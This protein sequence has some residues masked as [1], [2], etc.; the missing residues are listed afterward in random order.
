MF[1]RRVDEL[2]SA[3][4]QYYWSCRHS[5]CFC[6]YYYYCCFSHCLHFFFFLL[7]PPLVLGKYSVQ[8]NIGRI[9]SPFTSSNSY[10]G[11]INRWVIN[12]PPPRRACH[13]IFISFTFSQT[14][15]GIV[16][17]LCYLDE[18]L[19]K[20]P[21]A[22]IS[23][24]FIRRQRHIMKP[25]MQLWRAFYLFIPFV[26]KSVSLFVFEPRVLQAAFHCTLPPDNQSL[27]SPLTNPCVGGESW[28]QSSLRWFYLCHLQHVLLTDFY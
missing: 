6:F 17:L 20:V 21:L 1:Q 27:S 23:Q 26:W 2:C 18:V 11:R 7:P 16:W 5:A 12:Y 14:V 3:C 28:S 13:F 19:E 15:C 25:E 8:L 10:Y 9:N 24:H 4:C 22:V